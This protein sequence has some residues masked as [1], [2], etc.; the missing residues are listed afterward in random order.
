[1]DSNAKLCEDCGSLDYYERV[2]YSNWGTHTYTV[3]SQR[4]YD[5]NYESSDD[6]GD[7]NHESF[8]CCECN[9]ESMED[10]SGLTDDQFDVLYNLSPEL[11]WGA[12]QLM[13]NGVTVDPD[14]GLEAKAP[15]RKKGVTIGKRRVQP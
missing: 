6:S 5:E 3:D 1:M 14:T 2:S 11:R 7:E 12:Y 4:I 10:I 8:E 15:P 13:Q 9:C